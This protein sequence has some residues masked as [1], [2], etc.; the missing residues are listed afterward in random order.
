MLRAHFSGRSASERPARGV[1]FNAKKIEQSNEREQILCTS[2]ALCSCSCS[3]RNFFG[4]YTFAHV[5]SEQSVSATALLAR[6]GEMLGKFRR[7]THCIASS[8]RISTIDV[9]TVPLTCGTHMDPGRR[10]NISGGLIGVNSLFVHSIYRKN[11]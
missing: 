7:I 2:K 1:G 8:I 9:T 11:T 4:I 6:F 10:T 3:S 5:R